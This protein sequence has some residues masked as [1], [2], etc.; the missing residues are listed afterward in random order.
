MNDPILATRT[1]PRNPSSKVALTLKVRGGLQYL[2][3]NALPH[4]S[5][6]LDSHRK[7]F[8]GQCQ[9]GGCDHETILKYWPQFADLAA[10]HL[11]DI[12]GV[13][14]HAEPNGWYAL[15]GALPGN[16]GERYHAGNREQHFPKPVIDPAK[17]WADTDYRFPTPDECMQIFADHVR[18]PYQDARSVRDAVIEESLLDIGERYDWAAGRAWF[19]GWIKGQHPRWK[20]EAEACIAH[21]GLVVYGDKWEAA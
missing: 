4:F 1:I 8:P 11:S 20:A 17:P 14:M 7:G 2:R 10:L 5:L 15:A 9:S 3:G 13:P 21:H 19:S 16:A 6:T 18:M 12:H